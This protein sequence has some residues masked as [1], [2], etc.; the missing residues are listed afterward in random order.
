MSR[1]PCAD[2]PCDD[3]AICRAGICC[4]TL[5][6]SQ[7]AQLEAAIQSP[8]GGLRAA[9]AEEASTVPSLPELV[10]GDASAPLALS[11]S[12][13]LGLNPAPIADPLSHDSRK[14]AVH[15][16]PARS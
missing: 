11:A 1:H 4:A 10:R 6:A 14:E 15:V 3:C 5:T 13:R 9:I 8:V 12:A 2:H 16:I 7:R